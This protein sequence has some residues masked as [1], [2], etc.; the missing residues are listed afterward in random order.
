VHASFPN[1][2]FDYRCHDDKNDKNRKYN[3]WDAVVFSDE[4]TLQSSNIGRL[5]VYRPV[6][7]RYNEEYV[8]ATN[9]SGRFAVSV[10]GCIS[11]RGP[12][13]CAIVEERLR[14]P[15]YVRILREIMLPSVTHVFVW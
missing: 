5:R 2:N 11:I 8:H 4:K 6:G 9:R 3:I 1:F 12:G 13:V 10:W 7:T 15:V 14:A